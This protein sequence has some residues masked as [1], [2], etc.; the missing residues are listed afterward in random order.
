[1]HYTWTYSQDSLNANVRNRFERVL[2]D[3]FRLMMK[4]GIQ[5]IHRD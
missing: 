4:F 2:K 3:G 1:M 5:Y